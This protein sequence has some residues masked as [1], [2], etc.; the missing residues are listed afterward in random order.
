MWSVHNA[1]ALKWRMRW[2]MGGRGGWC[3]R[4]PPAALRSRLYCSLWSRSGFARLPLLPPRA[5][6]ALRRMLRTRMRMDGDPGRLRAS[7]IS[8]EARCRSRCRGAV[9]GGS[10]ERS[11]GEHLRLPVVVGGAYHWRAEGALRHT[12]RAGHYRF[13]SDCRPARMEPRSKLT[14]GAGWFRMRG[15]SGTKLA[16]SLRAGF[17]RDVAAALLL[18]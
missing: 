6:V 2:R 1:P 12:G 9:G 8:R 17:A 14:R 18:S 15:G 7:R 4:T 3:G 5:G 10:C 13:G 16:K 11:R